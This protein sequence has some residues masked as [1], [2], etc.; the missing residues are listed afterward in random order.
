MGLLSWIVVG[1]IAGW[2]ASIVMGTN[3]QQG[4]LMDIVVG[5]VGALVG[6]FVLSLL[7]TGSVSGFNIATIITATI[8]A[9]IVLFIWKRVGARS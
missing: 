9:I 8:G 1:A 3:S 4:C 7:G 6:G 2:L 5:V